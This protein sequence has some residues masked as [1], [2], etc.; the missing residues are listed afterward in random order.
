MPEPRT[1]VPWLTA[2]YF[3]NRQAFPPEELMKYG[4]QYVAFSW[5]GTHIVAS[6]LT[7][8]E[9][10][11]RVTAAGHDPERVVSAYVDPPDTA[12]A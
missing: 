3:R 9:L 2:E 8:E 6:A 1:G 10:E 11:D 7:Y 4:G 12:N 5:D